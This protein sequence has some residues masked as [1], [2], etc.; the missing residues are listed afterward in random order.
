MAL[1]QQQVEIADQEMKLTR[2]QTLPDISLGYSNQSFIGTIDQ[3]VY[4]SSDRFQ[5]FSVGLSIP[6]VFQPFRAKT[7]AAKVMTRQKEAEFQSFQKQLEGIFEQ[8]TEDWERQKSNLSY[9][10]EGANKNAQLI[11]E[12]SQQAYDAGELDYAAYWLSLQNALE[13]QGNYLKALNEYNQSVIR[14]EYLSAIPFD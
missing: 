8:A 14:L 11:Q 5:V 13:T 1:A 4:T 3:A 9:F 7:N 10:E 2:A 6:I 12:Q